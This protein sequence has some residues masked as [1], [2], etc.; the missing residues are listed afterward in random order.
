MEDKIKKMHQPNRQMNMLSGPMLNNIILFALPIAL[1][2]TLQQLF[3]AVGVAVVGRFASSEALAAVGGNT[4]IIT[5]MI[6]LFTGI[7]VGI[8]AVLANYIGQRRSEEKIQDVVHTAVTL[9]LIAGIVI[10]ILGEAIAAPILRLMQT[11]EEVL[12]LASL[13]LRI[14][15]IGLPFLTL[16]DF[17][18]AILRS[19]GDTR[20]PLYALLI[21]EV[22]NIG[23]TLL[24]VIV[25][26]MSVAGVAIATVVANAIS[27][28]IVFF[29]LIKE[30]MP[31]R[32]S[33]KKIGLR[34]EEVGRILRIGVPAGLQGVVFSLSNVTIQSGINSFGAMA[35]AGSSAAQNFEFFCYFLISGFAQA[36]VTFT[37]QNYGAMQFD[38]CKKAFRLCMICGV[39][40]CGGLS[41]LFIIGRVFFVQ[42]YTVDPAVIEF[43]YQR[44]FHVLIFQMLCCTYEIGG[45]ALRGLGRS[46]LPAVLTVL[47]T[48]VLR[49]I[50]IYTVFPIFGTFT[51]LMNVYPISWI[52]TGS[53]VLA[54]YFIIRR[55]IF[56][57]IVV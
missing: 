49:I 4:P 31:I 55:K 29:F 13:Y 51:S 50:W 2:S 12:P 56:R 37:S 22:V 8:N 9:A 17:G 5:L 7:S 11:P 54:A 35:I 39:L 42:L 15:L 26:Q 47:G 10:L 20:R 24:L 52:I 27:A 21:S 57:Q 41:M 32:V 44:M 16:Y 1:S 18:S 25:F 19:V 28:G 34:G 23:L 30:Q 43:A 48:C 46:M 3:N 36:A 6:N 33:L 53:C 14:F 40:A 45:S 38:R